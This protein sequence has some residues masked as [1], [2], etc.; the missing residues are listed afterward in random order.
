MRGDDFSRYQT[1][2][3][4][5]RLAV[6]LRQRTQATLPVS[7]GMPPLDRREAP[8][9]AETLRQKTRC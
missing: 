3:L 5:N 2:I 1:A 4:C 8:D 6:V 7:V 9:R